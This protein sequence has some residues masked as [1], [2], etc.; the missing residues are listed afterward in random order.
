MF[1]Y[2]SLLSER[3]QNILIWSA[4]YRNESKTFWFGPQ[5]I[6]LQAGRFPF[7]PNILGLSKAIWFWSGN[8]LR[9]SRTFLF[10]QKSRLTDWSKTFWFGSLIIGMKAKHFDL[11]QKNF[12]IT[13]SS[14]LF[15]PKNSGTKQSNLV[16]SGLEIVLGNV[17]RF[18]LIQKLI[19]R[20]KTLWFG[21]LS[22]GTRAKRFDLVRLLSEREQNNIILVRKLDQLNSISGKKNNFIYMDLRI[23]RRELKYKWDIQIFSR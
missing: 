1:R 6:F 2:R 20:S 21:L 13:S 11:V 14:F 22:I 16:W 3:K 4:Y 18:Y 8:C 23:V 9:Q 17:K 5:I 7:G 12:L 19:D 15:R 10:N